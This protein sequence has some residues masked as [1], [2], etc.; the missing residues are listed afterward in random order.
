MTNG[1]AR[2]VLSGTMSSSGRLG[3]ATGNRFILEL[4]KKLE[5]KPIEALKALIK[6]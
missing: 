4:E 6:K 5:P 3:E 1:I 2:V